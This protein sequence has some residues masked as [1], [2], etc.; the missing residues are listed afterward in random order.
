M[1]EITTVLGNEPGIQY[2]RPNDKTGGTGTA[3][4]NNAI[5]GKFKR[6]RIDQMMNITKQN[7]RGMLGFEPENPDYVAV[8]DALDTNVPS[9]KVLRIADGC[10][11]T[12]LSFVPTV[13]GMAVLEYELITSDPE[14]NRSGRIRASG[15]DPIELARA[16]FLYSGVD[17]MRQH[18]MNTFFDYTPYDYIPDNAGDGRITITGRNPLPVSP[19][20]EENYRRENFSVTLK[21]KF[22]SDLGGEDID[23]V[24]EQFGREITL[25]SCSARYNTAT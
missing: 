19:V 3:P 13:Q 1:P 22:A 6:G 8:Q 25:H 10:S 11:P 5:V 23:Y 18:Y 9:V 21:L 17:L 4:I 7:I 14:E 16:L 12:N 20:F 15:G 2:D 24:R